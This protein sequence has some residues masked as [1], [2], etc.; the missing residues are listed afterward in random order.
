MSSMAMTRR[1]LAVAATLILTI[2][3]IALGPRVLADEPPPS[4]QLN[5]DNIGP[6]PIEELTSK[7]ITRDYALAWQTLSHALAE[8]RTD[9]LD[10]YFT[11]LSKDDFAKL[12]AEQK[13]SGVR[14]RYHDHGH[15]LEAVFY[16]PA[17]DAMQLRDQ[18]Q[19][20]IDY[21]DGDKVLQTEQVNLRYVALMT[22]G[23]DRWM[24]RALEATPQAKP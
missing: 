22:P 14:I 9:L 13:K 18:A 10:G 17:G 6:R 7:T 24:V 15:K 19:L 8:N 23:A 4:V 12:I 3:I 2:G 20:D 1:M 16:S 11:G 21:L 5:S